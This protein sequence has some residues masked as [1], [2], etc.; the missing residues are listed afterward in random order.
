MLA[1]YAASPLYGRISPEVALVGSLV[2]ATGAAAIAIRADSRSVAVLGLLAATLAPP[3]MGGPVTLVTVVLLGAAL[4]GTS[5]IASYRPWAWLPA[6]A[7][8]TT[9]PQFASWL[10]DQA[11]IVPFALA[12][13]AAYWLVNALG[14]TG[15]ALRRPR[16]TVHAGSALH[17]VGLALF[18]LFAVRNTLVDE[19]ALARFVAL[20]VL[21][22]GY[23]LLAGP[24]VRR[25]AWREPMAVLLSAIAVGVVVMTI[26]LEI[27][28]VARPLSWTAI[29]LALAWVAVRF[30]RPPAAIGAG[31]VGSLVVLDVLAFIYP[32]QALGEQDASGSAV[33]FTSPRESRCS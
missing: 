32:V 2:V 26:A 19:P 7:F 31:V 12:A 8:M 28:G 9:S 24:F 1:F 23:A 25:S 17:L 15:Y 6:L 14:A 22:G 20:M 3:I 10:V 18:S 5:L 13:I 27:G 29:A 16:P 11:N 4:V 33:P 30:S 21:A